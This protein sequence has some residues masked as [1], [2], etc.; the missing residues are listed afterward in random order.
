MHLAQFSQKKAN[1][2]SMAVRTLQRR[3]NTSY[4]DILSSQGH[5]IPYKEG[6]IH[7]IKTSYQVKGSAYLTK[8]GQYILSRHLIKS[9]AVRTLQRR[10]NTSY[11]DILSSQ[12]HS[13][14]YKEGSIHLIK[15]RAVRTL[16]RRV[17]TSYQYILSSQGQCIPYKE[18]SIHPINT[19]YQVKG[20]AYLTKKG[21]YILS[22]HLIKSRAVRTLQRR[23]NTSYQDILSSQ[24]HSIPYKEGSIHLIKSKAVRTLQRRV[25][26]SY[27]Y[28]LSSQGQCI[29]Y[30]EGSIQPINTSY[31][32][33][34]SAYLTKKGQ[35]N[36]SIHLI[37]S[38]AVRTLQRRVNTSSQYIL[39]SKGQCI[40]YKEGSIHPIKSRAYLTEKGQVIL[41]R[42][43]IKSMAVHTLQRRVNT[44]YQDI[45]SSQW[46]C[47]PYREGSIHPIK[48]SYQ[49]NGSAYLT[50]KGSIHHIKRFYQVK[51]IPYLTKKVNTSFQDILLSKGSAYLTEKG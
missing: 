22:I 50:E 31:Q 18:G 17:N 3:V 46:Q 14:P 51:G 32:V 29:P 20:S 42:H 30:K 8:K 44:S 5:S 37:K 1:I 28:I 10:V 35:Y 2:K 45:L 34:G 26:T 47:I 40:P 27:Q 49:V 25:N 48:T 19:S 38:R 6:S 15:S 12:G 4:Q 23:V 36:L 16:Q 33:K 39:S 24:W 11:Q 13:I 7:P 9:R 21:Q 41:S 43:L